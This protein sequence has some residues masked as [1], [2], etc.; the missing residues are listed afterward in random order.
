MQQQWL[1][2]RIHLAETYI[3]FPPTM[4]HLNPYTPITMVPMWNL[5]TSSASS[6]LLDP[7]H[8]PLSARKD[9]TTLD[10]GQQLENELS[11]IR[12][13]FQTDL[14]LSQD[15]INLVFRM[16]ASPCIDENTEKAM[17]SEFVVDP[18]EKL[19]MLNQSIFIDHIIE[20]DVS[21]V[22]SF[23]GLICTQDL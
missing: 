20:G 7:I 12:S 2:S 23:A 13:Q 3:S 4:D 10:F 11:N 18:T 6:D 14:P 17:C 16:D 8:P 22:P 15:V 19:S 5:S 9:S 21:K 1:T